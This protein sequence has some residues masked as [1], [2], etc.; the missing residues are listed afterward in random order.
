MRGQLYRSE[1][2]QEIPRLRFAPL[3]MTNEEMRTRL[4]GSQEPQE[5]SSL[6]LAPVEMTRE[7]NANERA[8]AGARTRI[9]VGRGLWQAGKLSVPLS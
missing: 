1:E 2:D 6:R 9:R 8:G 4:C 3:G 5:I 7:E